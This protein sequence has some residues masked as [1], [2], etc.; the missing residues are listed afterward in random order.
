MKEAISFQHFSSVSI[1]STTK[2]RNVTTIGTSVSIITKDR[3][4]RT[5]V[6]NATKPVVST[7]IQPSGN[8]TQENQLSEA[9]LDSGY[10]EF[11][12]EVTVVKSGRVTK[13]F[14]LVHLQDLL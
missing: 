11:H 5:R 12:G 6:V 7:P 8:I 3:K 2:R 1:M 14:I 10:D 13:V 9:F 4:R